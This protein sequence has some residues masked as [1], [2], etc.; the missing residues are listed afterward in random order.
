[1]KNPAVLFS[2][3][4]FSFCFVLSTV[5]EEAAP[6]DAAQAPQEVEQAVKEVARS[7]GGCLVSESAI[8]DMETREARVKEA[9]AKNAQKESELNAL[10]AA[11]QEQLAALDETK[12]KIQGIKQEEISK[13]EAKVKKLIDTFETMSPK[14][15]ASVVAKIDEEIAV[16]ALVRLST[17]KAGKILAAMDASKSAHLSEMM[18]LG[19]SEKKGAAK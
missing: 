1:M 7:S 19:T 17:T 10:Q 5:A 8:A 2:V 16:T 18:V 15:A 9:E 13:N 14:A 4:V 6:V 3:I 11:V 12:K